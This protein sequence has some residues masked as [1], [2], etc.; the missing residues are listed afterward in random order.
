MEP[1]ARV[2]RVSSSEL[3]GVVFVPTHWLLRKAFG[4]TA[5]ASKN[6][7]GRTS[8]VYELDNEGRRQNVG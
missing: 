4:H 1:R 6:A 7:I 8:D 5:R 2:G 3:L